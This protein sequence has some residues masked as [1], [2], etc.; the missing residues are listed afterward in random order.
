MTGA[1]PAFEA[2][3]GLCRLDGTRGCPKTL[4]CKPNERELPDVAGYDGE[5]VS[6]G[7][8]GEPECDQGD[9]CLAG[10]TPT[11]SGTCD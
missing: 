9:P 11:D 8:S 1:P 7:R 10:L 6:C 4:L 5:C 3:V 2:P